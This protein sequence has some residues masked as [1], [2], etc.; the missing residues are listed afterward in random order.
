[1]DHVV[2]L[3]APVLTALLD[4]TNTT[5]I[6]GESCRK[7]PCGRVHE[8]D[9]LYFVCA[10]H[11]VMAQGRVGEVRNVDRPGAAHLEPAAY[12]LIAERRRRR[13]S[14]FYQVLVDVEHAEAVD[15]FG[16]VPY[17]TGEDWLIVGDIE[18]VKTA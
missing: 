14:R 6:C 11:T 4:G 7:I 2:Y 8:G 18:N 3:D 16:I 13:A 17:P 9:K 10:D 12:N 5:L 15:P 1:M